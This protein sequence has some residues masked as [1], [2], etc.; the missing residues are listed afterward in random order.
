[1]IPMRALSKSSEMAQRSVTKVSGLRPKRPEIFRPKRRLSRRRE[2]V[3]CLTTCRSSFCPFGADSLKLKFS[4]FWAQACFTSSLDFYFSRRI[5][6][7]AFLKHNEC[8]VKSGR[9]LK[10]LRDSNPRPVNHLRSQSFWV[11]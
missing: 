7:V 8:P 3:V 5:R 1:M 9:K 11:S 6:S 10:I 4:Q 2:S